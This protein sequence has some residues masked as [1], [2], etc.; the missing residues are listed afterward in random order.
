MYTAPAYFMSIVVA[1]TIYMLLK[2]FQDRK[3]SQN[4]KDIKKKSAKRAAIDDHA[5]HMTVIGLTVYDCCIIGCMMLNV[6]TKGS[7]GC[8]ETLGISIAESQFA[9]SSTIAGTVVAT[10]GTVGVFALLSMGKLSQFFSDIQLISGGMIV[11]SIGI[12]SLTAIDEDGANSSWR[13]YLSIF[14]IYSIGYP[15]GHTAV[16]GLFSKSKCFGA[17]AVSGVETNPFVVFSCWTKTSG[18]AAWLVCIRWIVCTT[19]FPHSF[20]IR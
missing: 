15:I 17:H 8:F 18:D 16:I 20:W 6:S 2:Y 11:M 5:N 10:C 12:L 3:R 7:I 9:I 13:Y 19:C 14:M 4:P 1:L